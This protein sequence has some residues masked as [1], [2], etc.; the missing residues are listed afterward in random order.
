[1][2]T[3]VT[4]FCTAYQRTLQVELVRR[5]FIGELESENSGSLENSH[6]LN[7][8]FTHVAEAS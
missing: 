5:G 4:V 8:R 2:T 1:M 7:L 3:P 6:F